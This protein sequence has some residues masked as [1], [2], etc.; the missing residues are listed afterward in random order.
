M[1]EY[2]EPSDH[3]TLL[4]LMWS[5]ET[6]YVYIFYHVKFW[7]AVPFGGT[8]KR[9]HS[10]VGLKKIYVEKQDGH[11]INRFQ[12]QKTEHVCHDCKT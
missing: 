6:S 10:R 7:V 9:L 5:L 12:F 1:K 3:S 2:T 4:V 8:N 11:V